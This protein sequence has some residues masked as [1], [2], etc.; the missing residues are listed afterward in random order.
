[1]R[2]RH[3][4]WTS[5]E[6]AQARRLIVSSLA[7]A[8][9]AAGG[10]GL[11]VSLAAADEVPQAEFTGPEKYGFA[12]AM[13]ADGSTAVVG[14]LGGSSAAAAH[15]L[16]FD[17]SSWTQQAELTASDPSYDQLFGNTV[18]LS[19]DGN[20]VIV[21]DPGECG[22]GLE[23]C[24]H[25]A[26]YIFTRS[27]S[28]WTQQSELH[29]GS[30]FGGAVALSSDG[31]TGL[32]G[33]GLSG[34]GGMYFDPSGNGP[35]TV[36]SRSDETWTQD[37]TLSASDASAPYDNFGHAVA[38]SGDGTTALIGDPYRHGEAGAAYVF[39]GTGSSWTQ[40]AELTGNDV[41][42][43]EFGTAVAL[44]ADGR[45]AL[46]GAPGWSVTKEGAGYVFGGSGPSWTLQAE[47]T[48]SDTVLPPSYGGFGR[49]VALSSDGSIAMIGAPSADSTLGAAYAFATNGSSWT[50]Q[51][52]FT[53]S[54]AT[55]DDY[56]GIA[57]ALNAQGSTTLIGKYDPGAY[58][59]AMPSIV[60]PLPPIGTNE[61]S[62]TNGVGQTLSTS[63]AGGATSASGGATSGSGGGL[64]AI[65]A[66]V[67]RETVSPTVFHAAPRGASS[68]S[69]SRRYGTDVSYTLNE[70][71]SVSFTVVQ[72]QSGREARGG[73]CA[74][75]TKAN[76]RGVGCMRLVTL[77]GS[78]TRA[79]SAGAN[80]FR[81]TGR[82]AGRTLKAGRYQLVATPSAGAKTGST[83][84]ASFRVIK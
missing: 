43:G 66:T 74:E 53:A 38:L 70:P 54:D 36:F 17:G 81:F 69:A 5:V 77:P 83:A 24:A 42:R 79:G 84:T 56:F 14:Q 61:G 27:G 40:Q 58:F 65:L 82:L 67:G 50:Q 75:A 52:K 1:M 76:R 9:V 37:A 44:S 72:T 80:R 30:G 8:M 49:G 48:A 47:L 15:I 68:G 10:G 31:N 21:G 3:A 18:A 46:V 63:G 12:A 20:T 23:N 11:S 41:G 64:G 22:Y 39:T 33:A 51:A 60:F 71:A 73:R 29:G 25:G 59:F 55:P 6:T 34:W 13:S 45:T 16:T 2:M 26:A 19:A 57:V 7:A 78:F 62:T 35:P 4:F 28:T 32:V